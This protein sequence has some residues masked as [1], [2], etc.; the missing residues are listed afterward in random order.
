MRIL[1]LLSAAALAGVAAPALAQDAPD[2]AEVAEAVNACR[3][4][5]DANWI[6]LDRL[7]DHDF[8]MAEKRGSRGKRRQDQENGQN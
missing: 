7:G 2:A 1:T 5:T 8:H 4:I 6:H 3:A